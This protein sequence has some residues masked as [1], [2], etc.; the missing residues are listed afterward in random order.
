MTKGNEKRHEN[1]RSKKAIISGESRAVMKSDKIWE[2][3]YVI[4]FEDENFMAK[5]ILSFLFTLDWNVFKVYAN[6]ISSVGC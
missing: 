2:C 5:N 3:F 1:A 6:I 4:A